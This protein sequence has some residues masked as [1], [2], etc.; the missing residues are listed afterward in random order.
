[1]SLIRDILGVDL[2]TIPQDQLDDIVRS[3]RIAR[4]AD[5]A[6]KE[7]KKRAPAAKKETAA[8]TSSLAD[9]DENDW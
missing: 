9:F 7:R 6:P 5:A 4:E 3:G 8:M 1:M 2:D